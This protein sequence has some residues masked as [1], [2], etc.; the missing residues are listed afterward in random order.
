MKPREPRR[1]TLVR[2]R[3][4]AGGAWHDACILNISSSG[5]GMQAAS[6]PP[7]GAYLEIRRGLHVIVGR[8]MWSREH[9]FGVKAQDRLP[10]D[11]LADNSEAALPQGACPSPVERRSVP[12]VRLSAQER[13]R[14]AG[15]RIEYVFAAV[16]ALCIASFV[17]T[18]V[19]SVLAAPADMVTA[20]LGGHS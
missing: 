18:E 10:V 15:R 19:H 17:A 3:V 11:L 14:N 8:V 7:R 4:N 12:R 2:A 1:K 13:S 5:L 16:L 9:R 6:P 20:A